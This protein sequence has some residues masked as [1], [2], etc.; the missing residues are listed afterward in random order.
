[1]GPRSRSRV[2]GSCGL[3]VLIPTAQINLY[4]DLGFRLID[5]PGCG[6]ARISV[7]DVRRVPDNACNEALPG[8]KVARHATPSRPGKKIFERENDSR[9]FRNAQA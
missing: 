8:K 7:G 4:A 5:E 6:L 9:S 3:I 1:M 2:G